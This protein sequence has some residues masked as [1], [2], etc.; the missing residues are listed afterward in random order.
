M[1]KLKSF[2]TSEHRNILEAKLS[3]S[4]ETSKPYLDKIQTEGNLLND[5]VMPLGSNNAISFHNQADSLTMK[6]ENGK[7]RQFKLHANAIQQLGEKLEAPSTY[8]KELAVS[9]EPWKLNLASNILNEHSDHTKRQRVLVREVAGTVRGVMSDK[10]RR[11]NTGEIYSQFLKASYKEGLSVYGAYADDLKSWIEVVNPSIVSIPTEKNISIEVIYGARI[12]NSDFGQS[13]LELRLFT[14]QVVCLNGMTRENIIR[15]IHIGRQI[16]DNIQVSEKTYKYDTQT[17]ASLVK[18][19]IAGLLSKEN[20]L[21]Q[22]TVIQKAVATEV[23]YDKEFTKL[24]K[25]GVSKT[26]V[27]ETKKLLTAHRTNDGI[28]GEG[29]SLFNLA[30]GLSAVARN[31]EGRRERELQEIAGKL[32]DQVKI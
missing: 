24:A 21:K 6:I 11:L 19:M 20:I 5:F 32:L 1:S 9:G 10:Y 2:T 12:S 15:Q 3:R 23:D 7:T 25:V 27:E 13:A 18:D 16:P 31:K 29:S 14:V 22:S 30:Q 8:L 28:I 26:E 17:Q 4:L